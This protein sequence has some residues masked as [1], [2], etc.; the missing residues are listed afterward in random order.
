MQ[1]LHMSVKIAD[2]ACQIGGNISLP[3]VKF[4]QN[5][6]LFNESMYLCTVL[7]K[8]ECWAFRLGTIDLEMET[9]GK[10]I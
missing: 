10:T 2:H 4:L 3:I 6:V 1:L 5:I 7:S 8:K 9:M